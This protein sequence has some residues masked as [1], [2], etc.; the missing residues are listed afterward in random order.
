MSLPAENRFSNYGEILKLLS[1]CWAVFN[2]QRFPRLVGLC[3]T[4]DA[5]K[6]LVAAHSDDDLALHV[7][8]CRGSWSK[9]LARIKQLPT[10]TAV[11][12][13][14]SQDE[15][16]D[17]VVAAAF[18]SSASVPIFTFDTTMLAPLLTLRPSSSQSRALTLTA[19]ATSSPPERFNDTNFP[20]ASQCSG[21]QPP[22]PPIY[23]VFP[24]M[25]F[26]RSYPQSKPAIVRVW[27]VVRHCVS[28]GE[29]KGTLG[30]GTREEGGKSCVI[31]TAPDSQW[32]DDTERRAGEGRRN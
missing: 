2:E 27:S 3:G 30:G 24:H 5:L 11:S 32:D 16:G 18:A 10:Q 12:E 29:E 8:C 22:P 1:S 26:S 15:R 20:P 9:V 28:L 4:F 21:I 7:L 25:S 31:S 6:A 19:K 23:T 14:F 17:T 13:L